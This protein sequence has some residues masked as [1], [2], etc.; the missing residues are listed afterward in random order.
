MNRFKTLKYICQETENTNRNIFWKDN[1][2]NNNSNNHYFP[3]IYS[4]E[5]CMPKYEGGSGIE[6]MED[7][8]DSYLAK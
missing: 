1:H 3:I 8:N 6:K 5:I 2:D 4:L 7:I